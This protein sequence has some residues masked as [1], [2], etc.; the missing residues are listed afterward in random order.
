MK[1]LLLSAGSSVHTMR[2][3][4][5]YVARGLDVH[6]VTQHQPLTGFSSEVRVHRIPHFGGL[7]YLINGPRL[8]RI[9]KELK[10]DVVNAHYAT[11]Y[12]TLARH[13]VPIPLVLNVWGSD[14]YSFPNKSKPHL[15][16]VRTNLAIAN[17]IVSTSNAMAEQ[18]RSLMGGAVNL[19]VVPF[20]VDL[21]RFRPVER[22]GPD[23]SVTIGTVK[24]LEPVYGVDRLVKAFI[25]LRARKD[26]PDLK[27]RIV[28][29]GSE[30]DRLVSDLHRAGVM[31]HAHFTGA[32]P[33]DRVPEE[34]RKLDIYVALSRS[35][36]FGVSVIE[37]SASGLPVVVSDVGGLP[38]VV[39]NGVSGV[40]VDGDDHNAIVETLADLV[41]D[42]PR[43]TRLGLAGRSLVQGKYDW[44]SG[45]DRMV[46]ILKEASG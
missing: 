22:A 32:V 7:G 34:L 13:C 31:V 43:R 15:I 27:L 9:V 25:S 16:W 26:L 33:H 5:A 2:W 14:V 36:S 18:V 30:R 19:E 8:Q 11:G 23:P 24:S 21:E 35:E 4:N 6:L 12:G 10:P 20:G 37:A 41:K 3:A 28:G 38:E 29:A 40:V 1:V 44:E 46:A 42:Q 39:E 17:T 45:V